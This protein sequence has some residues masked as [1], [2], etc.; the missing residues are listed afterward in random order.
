[1]ANTSSLPDQSQMNFNTIT[2]I[3]NVSRH[4]VDRG[5]DSQQVMEVWIV[6]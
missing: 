3:V 4:I 2:S 6:R 5:L 1:M